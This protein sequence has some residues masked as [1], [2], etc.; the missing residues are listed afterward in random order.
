MKRV[1]LDG[2]GAD[3][4]EFIQSLPL[5]SGRVELELEGRVICNVVPPGFEF[6]DAE[7]AVL[8][9]RGRE[10]VHRSRQ[11]NLNVPEQVIEEEVANAVDEVRR[12]NAR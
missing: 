1:I 9:Q 3:V 2:A 4:K 6:S 5:Q 7:R 11:R 10:L 8:L 12:R